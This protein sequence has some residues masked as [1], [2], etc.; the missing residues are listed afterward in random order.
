M[1]KDTTTKIDTPPPQPQAPTPQVHSPLPLL[2][3]VQS[4]VCKN[5]KTQTTPLW[6]RDDLGQVLCNACGLFLKLHG[7]PRPILLK[8][9]TI[10]LRNRIKLGTNHPQNHHKLMPNTPELR[11]NHDKSRRPL[12]LSPK[13][14][15]GVKRKSLGD[16]TPLMIKQLQVGGHPQTQF[17]GPIPGGATPGLP[18]VNHP[19]FPNQSAVQ[20]LHYPTL[21]PPLFPRGLERITSPLLLSSATQHDRAAALALETMSLNELG[22]VA[23]KRVPPPQGVLLIASNSHPTQQQGALTIFSAV[24]MTQASNEPNAATAAAANPNPGA[25]TNQVPSQALPSQATQQQASSLPQEPSGSLLAPGSAL[26]PPLGGSPPNNNHGQQSLEVTALKTRI[27]ELELV[28]DLYRT[29]IIELEAMEQALRL[30]EDLMRHRL[31]D[32]MN[33]A[34]MQ[35]VVPVLNSQAQQQIGRASCRERV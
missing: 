13:G 20:P 14:A 7:R 15:A 21:V 31:E 32:M 10:K 5:C 12:G 11:A 33:L 6:R 34:N 25:P 29:R 16:Y 4:P 2:K 8:T 17:N 18:A 27:L 24:N 1:F 19:R 26:Q 9:D 3:P 30:R 23:Y 28:N 22:H 35:G